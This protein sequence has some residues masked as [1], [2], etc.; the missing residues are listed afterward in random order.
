MIEK[1]YKYRIYPNKK[2]QIL[3]GKHFGASRWIFNYGLE[4]K[5]K[6][7]Q[8]NKEQL[9][10][11]QISNQIPKLKKQET[12]EWLKE[13]NAQSLQMSLRQLD[14]AYTN[15]FRKHSRFPKFKN[16]KGKQSFNIPQG[17]KID[18]K[19][20]K[21]SFIK[22]GKIKIKIDRN[23]EGKI[24]KATIS[25]NNINQYFVSYTVEEDI[26]LPKLKKIKEKT[27][28]GID[29]G[30]KDFAILSNGKKIKNPKYLKSSEQR[31]KVL[32]RRLS[33][34]QKGSQNRKK[35]RLR[36]A[37][38]HNKIT[39][40]RSAFL[41]NFTYQ[42]TH[43]NQVNTY[44]IEDLNVNG[45][46]KNHCLA[47]AIVDVSW[48]EFVK[49]LSYKCKWYGKNL[50]VI[51][52]FEPSSKM[53]SC[54]YINKELK[55]SDRKWTCPKCKTTHDR[56]ILAAN[57]IKKFALLPLLKRIEPVELSH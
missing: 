4:Q 36:V 3:L 9:S 12:T 8:K 40:Q 37:K 38:I 19:N 14:N 47:K 41:H 15:F 7:Y 23:F 45:M 51:G 54:G 52:R 6:V 5:I 26:K 50:L 57:N 32:Q 53:C 28:I 39:N 33:K 49:Q 20:K 13:I 31:L 30:L 46:M 24:I 11:F 56:D 16:K 1:G 27:T 18:W 22:I 25:K 2:Q 44:A 35:A 48:S 42:L 43:D 29:L 55:L 21:A 17:N 10:C 34:K